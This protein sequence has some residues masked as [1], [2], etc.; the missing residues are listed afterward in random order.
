MT[1]EPIFSILIANYNNSIFLQDCIES[2]K[3]QSYKK[4]EVIFVDDCSNDDSI[5]IYNKLT[6]GL[7]YF[8]L[9]VNEK[10]SGC[11]FTKAR[12]ADLASG[13]LMGF[14]DPDDVLHNDAIEVMVKEH[15][16]HP[17]TSI[18]SSTYYEC[19]EK[20]KVK[21]VVDSSKRRK[22]FIS[23]LDNPWAITHFATFKKSAYKKTCGIDI[24]MKRAVDQDLYFKMEEQGDVLFLNKPLYYYRMNKNSI[25]LNDNNYKA[26]AWH[27]YAIVFA[28]KRRGLEF[29][30]YCVI[31]SVRGLQKLAM[32]IEKIL[33]FMRNSFL[34]FFSVKK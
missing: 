33:V 13:E 14:L 7:S 17:E 10:N 25:S 11:G 27:I 1:N 24:S 6:S 15:I 34:E 20:L 3:N 21:R 16:N 9:F 4:L 2:I 12:C 29:D 26:I 31:L 28:C 5:D 8:K 22:N 23:Q 19:N 18:I 30:K 32:K